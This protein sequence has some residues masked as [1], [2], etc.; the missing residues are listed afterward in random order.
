LIKHELWGKVLQKREVAKVNTTHP[1]GEKGKGGRALHH[2]E[3]GISREKGDRRRH[4]VPQMA[5][6]AFSQNE[7]CPGGNREGTFRYAGK[8]ICGSFWR[9]VM[10]AMNER[11]E[12][13]DRK[14]F[15]V[16]KKAGPG[17]VQHTD[18]EQD[19]NGWGYRVA[20][21]LLLFTE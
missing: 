18:V 13:V 19:R 3:S 21:N 10:G 11:R 2:I 15:Y 5:F 16:L 14:K 1:N 17:V 9:P 4:V 12:A 20:K 6:K 7:E 8:G